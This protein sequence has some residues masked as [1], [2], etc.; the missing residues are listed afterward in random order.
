M[1]KL[2]QKTQRYKNDIATK[3]N[4]WFKVWGSKKTNTW[5]VR[6]IWHLIGQVRDDILQT[7]AKRTQVK[8]KIFRII[9]PFLY[10]AVHSV[11]SHEFFKT[12]ALLFR[13]I[14]F[15]KV[16]LVNHVFT[17]SRM[18]IKVTPGKRLSLHFVLF[19]GRWTICA[20]QFELL[21]HLQQRSHRNFQFNVENNLG[22]LWFSS[23]LR[24]AQKL[25]P[26]TE[27]A[28]FHTKTS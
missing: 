22:L 12:R 5:Y 17:R 20:N 1:E 10:V 6:F 27:S 15:F 23:R 11:P 18:V 3:V 25:A 7:I 2:Q 9:L 16:R 14:I 19:N 13:Y 26:L 24:I 4:N 28:R 8:S 21:V